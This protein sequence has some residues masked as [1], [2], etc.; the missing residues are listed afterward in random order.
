MVA[1]DR[2]QHDL[3]EKVISPL[4]RTHEY[5]TDDWINQISK[6]IDIMRVFTR[7]QA[8]K[9]LKAADL[10][11]GLCSE[12]A[13]QVCQTA[14]HELVGKKYELDSIESGAL[15]VRDVVSVPSLPASRSRSIS[16]AEELAAHATLLD[17]ADGAN[18]ASDTIGKAVVPPQKAHR[19]GEVTQKED[20]YGKRPEEKQSERPDEEE[21]RIADDGKLLPAGGGASAVKALK[22]EEE[23]QRQK[24][25]AEVD[26]TSPQSPA[27]LT[28]PPPTAPAQGNRRPAPAG[29]KREAASSMSAAA[30]PNSATTAFDMAA[31]GPEAL[32]MNDGRRGLSALWDKLGGDISDDTVAQSRKFIDDA[33]AQNIAE[34]REYD[35]VK[36]FIE[37]LNLKP[38]PRKKFM[39]FFEQSP[40]AIA[41]FCTDGENDKS[42]GTQACATTGCNTTPEARAEVEREAAKKLPEGVAIAPRVHSEA[43]ESVKDSVLPELVAVLINH[44]F[45]A[46]RAEKVAIALGA[47]NLDDLA[48]LTD[49]NVRK[50]EGLNLNPVEMGKFQLAKNE[51][52]VILQRRYGPG[53]R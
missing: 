31:V 21:K 25:E 15:V 39:A 42:G 8:D 53:K 35:L 36:D 43:C 26:T 50:Y 12:E 48:D 28:P 41:A 34:I 44:R 24:E 23:E 3:I 19:T 13:C 45:T 32:R 47:L 11:L 49:D 16:K 5:T 20:T 2:N 6:A 37:C 27:A 14:L 4:R 52:K 17:D 10:D 29:V 33:G 22:A 1:D 7:E 46:P 51:A 18:C 30:T 38:I 9:F 40:S